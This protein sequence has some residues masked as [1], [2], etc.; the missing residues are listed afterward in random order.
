MQPQTGCVNAEQKWPKKFCWHQVLKPSK[1][2]VSTQEGVQ[3][4]QT[5]LIFAVSRE[6]Y[7]SLCGNEECV[8]NDQHC[9]WVINIIDS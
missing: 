1:F 5:F 2:Y 4:S 6:E 9:N 8:Q 3:S 7:C